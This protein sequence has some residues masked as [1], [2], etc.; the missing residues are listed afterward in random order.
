MKPYYD[1]A[2]IQIFHGDCR[3]ILPQLD[4]DVVI[5]DPVYPRLTYGWEYVPIESFGL[6]CRQFYFWMQP[7][8]SFPLPFTAMHIW[9]KANV[10]IGDHE[11]WE[12]IYEVNGK[13]IGSV[14]RESSINS[15][16]A[17]QMNSDKFYEH[18]CQKP[19]KLMTKLIRRTEG[20]IADPFSG[21]GSTLLAA[22]G[23]DRSAIGIEIEEKYCEIAAKRLSQE[24]F[25]F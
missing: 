10:Y 2:G 23:L 17:A 6:E 15:A 16:M 25:K 7:P 19:L 8:E 22:K 18:P 20:R 1:H 14:L 9:S 21:S 13:R 11:L 12:P 24:V 4:F 5:T 3:E